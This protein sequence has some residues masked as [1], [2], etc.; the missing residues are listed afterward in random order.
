MEKTICY[1]IASLLEALIL[2]QYASSLFKP[3]FS[4]KAALFLFILFYELQLP[5]LLADSVPNNLF[6]FIV[7]NFSLML[8]LYHIKW[9]AAFFH[10]LATA[11]IM[12]LSELAILSILSNI[13]DGF[14]KE[15]SYIQN[16]FILTATSKML[17]FIILRFIIHLVSQQPRCKQ[18]DT[19]QDAVPGSRIPAQNLNWSTLF[20]FTIPFLSLF[21]ILT[22]AAICLDTKLPLSL[23]WM[24]TVST[25]FLVV[26]NLLI[27]GIYYYLQKKDREF[28][29]L[30]LL[31]QKE[32]DT[33]KYNRML[34]KQDEN[35]KIL[36]H[37]IKKHLQSLA[38]L[39]ERGE[40]KKIAS[41]IEQIIHSSYLQDSIRLCDNE[42]LNAILCRYISNCND[43]NISFY[44]HITNGVLNFLPYNDLTSLF[45]NLL[46][47]AVEAAEKIPESYIELNI[48]YQQKASQ[49][50]ITLINSCQKNPFSKKTGQLIS[51]KQNHPIHGYGIKSIKRIVK[52]YNGEIHMYYN[53]SHSTFH[54]IM[55]LRGE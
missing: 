32:S 9:H 49:T 6:V 4:K 45:C 10:S 50:I 7:T 29:E 34:L 3:R 41:Y 39:N 38:S 22:L 16:I 35:Q 46:D 25:L 15:S 43:R 36:I 33:E 13:A 54:T 40:Q 5:I 19:G 14:Y 23:N 27:F 44:P 48:T 28:I 2:W 51:Q 17:Y 53:E 18:K 55:T 12:G 52:K 30:Q 26:I 47:N 1:I 42:L 11:V 21:I 31:L 37:D 8:I 20:L 24:I